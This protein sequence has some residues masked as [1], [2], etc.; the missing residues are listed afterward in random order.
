VSPLYPQSH[1]AHGWGTQRGM[2]DATSYKVA[3]LRHGQQV[4]PTLARPESPAEVPENPALHS[5]SLLG[6]GFPFCEPPYNSRTDL[7]RCYSR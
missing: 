1:E 2:S 3:D 5:D 7:T 4:G 6:A